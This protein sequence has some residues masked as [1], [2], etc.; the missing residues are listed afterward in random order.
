MGHKIAL[1]ELDIGTQ[2]PQQLSLKKESHGVQV[3]GVDP[4]LR[5]HTFLTDYPQ[6]QLQT[7]IF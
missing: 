4:T 2:Q 1:F 6:H 5:C 7:R 3:L